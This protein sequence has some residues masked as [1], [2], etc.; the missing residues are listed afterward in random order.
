MNAPSL[1]D[2]VEAHPSAPPTWKP[3]THARRD[4]PPTSRQAAERLRLKA[5]TQC[6]KVLAILREGPIANTE[7]VA[8]AAR[9]GVLN[10]RAR[11]SDLRGWGACI[12]V[13]DGV[14]RL[15]RDVEVEG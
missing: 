2:A 8:R 1:F 11:C 9:V 10:P 13:R 4:D 7:L 6:G 15:T 12:D 5:D 14:Y 3:S